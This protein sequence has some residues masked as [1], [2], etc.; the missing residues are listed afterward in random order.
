ML[1][2]KSYNLN[3]LA[4]S[5][6]SITAAIFNLSARGESGGGET[7][8]TTFSGRGSVPLSTLLCTAI[9]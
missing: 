2:N 6:T 8:V 9:E 1:D 7:K 3:K 4:K 5:E